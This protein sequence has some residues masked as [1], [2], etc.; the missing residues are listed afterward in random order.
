MYKS[1]TYA[2]VFPRAAEISEDQDTKKHRTTVD[3]AQYYAAGSSGT[4]T[5]IG[6]DTIII[7]DPLKPTDAD[8]DVVRV[9]VNNNYDNTIKSR[10]NDRA[11]GAI[12]IVMQRLHDDD[13][14]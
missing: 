13:L 3:G 10:L 12:I 14:C 5:G 8:S 6:A 1:D 11:H 9:G 4:I 7:D 2:K